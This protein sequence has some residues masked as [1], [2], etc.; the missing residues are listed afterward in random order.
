MLPEQVHHTTYIQ[1]SQR[2]FDFAS[3]ISK[4][5]VFAKLNSVSQQNSP[6]WILVSETPLQAVQRVIAESEFHWSQ[7]NCDVLFMIS[8]LFKSRATKN[9]SR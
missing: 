6:N 4:P 5:G 1:T 2:H 9:I 7:F 3:F 8:N